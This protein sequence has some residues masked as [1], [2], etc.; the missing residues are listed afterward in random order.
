MRWVILAGLAAASPALAVE[1]YEACLA[2]VATEPARAEREA[3]D[4]ARFGGG[5]AARHCHALALIAIGAPGAG[6]DVLLDIAA[7]E[8]MPER[9]RAEILVQAGELLLEE[10]DAV[11]AGVTAA[12]ALALVPD[13]AEA[14][15]LR[16][17]IRAEQGRTG[18]ALGD[19]DLAL[20]KGGPNVRL[21]T[22]RSAAKRRLGDMVAARA[23]AVWATELQP[24]DAGAWLERGIVEARIRDREAARQSLLTAISLD[25]EGTVGRAAQ[26]ALQKMDAGIE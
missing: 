3:G 17:A 22:L 16:A 12:Q 6:I 10:G 23:D 18:D 4:W 19:L 1:D 24:E 13:M 26:I 11:T 9:P 25:T 7:E 14:L 8:P 21:L 20:T 15:I 5:A 2:L